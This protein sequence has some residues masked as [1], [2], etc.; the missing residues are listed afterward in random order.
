MHLRSMVNKLLTLEKKSLVGEYVGVMEHAS[1]AHG[2]RP[3]SGVVVHLTR[4]RFLHRLV[5]ASCQ[6]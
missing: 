3:E 6:C 2:I 5:K 1:L 4:W